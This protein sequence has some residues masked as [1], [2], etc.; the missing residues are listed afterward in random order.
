MVSVIGAVLIL[1][2]LWDAFET[3]VL[4]R[5]VA[6][7]LRITGIYFRVLGEI[8]FAI[9]E[10]MRNARRREAYLSLF[11]PLSLI[12]L[13]ATWAAGLV[14]S[15]ALI[16]WEAGARAAPPEETAN[17]WT[18]LYFSG[19]TFFTL[20]LG[21][22]APRT[23][24]GRTAAIVEAGTGFVLL[25]LVIGYLPVLYQ[26][27]S[28][29]EAEISMLDEWAGSPP[30]AGELLRRLGRWDDIT[31][32]SAFF[33]KWEEWA[34]DLLES[35]I[36][37]PILAGFRSQHGNQSWLAGLTTILDACAL[38]I[39]SIEGVP[40]RAAHL[41]FAMARHVAVDLCQVL[42]SPPEASAEDRLP[43]EEL[44][45]L[46]AVLR[47]ADV[48]VREDEAAAAAL[49][50]LRAMYEP[51]VNSLADFLSLPLPPWLPAPG[52]RDNWQKSKW[53]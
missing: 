28:R 17:F 3:V 11:G 44:T 34:A 31:A 51:Y 12:L 45:R 19:S 1:L 10:R 52:A 8:W 24:L 46:R 18:A 16:H 42:D 43:R 37:Y 26:A 33:G 15:F 25:A 14:L 50:D 2:I 20:G 53:D 30:S 27:F 40:R 29:R 49:A 48:P 38:V 7:R 35:H 39:S 5:R 22:V 9:A 41:T 21:D 13:L 4:P 23:W 36:S 6:R 47:E 32:V